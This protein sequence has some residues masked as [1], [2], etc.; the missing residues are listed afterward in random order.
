MEIP[1]W[2]D[3]VNNHHA[4]FVDIFVVLFVEIK[5]TGGF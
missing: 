4:V 1:S 3:I 5:Q 2:I